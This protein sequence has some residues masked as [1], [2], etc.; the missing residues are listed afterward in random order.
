MPKFSGDR[1]AKILTLGAMCFALFMAMLDNTV[2]NVA[3][4]T[5]QR[6]L[7]AGV[8]GL[9][10]IVDGY[11]LAFA[12]LLLTGGILGDRYGRKRTFLI[13][14]TVFTLAS[15]G[16]GLS[17][18]AG[19]LIAARAV[20]GIGGALLM[21][22]T[23][24]IL[25][26]TVP[27][28]E[29]AKAIGTWAGISGL[30]LALG[31]TA[32]GWLI[33]HVGWEA[34]F[35]LNVPIGALAFAVAWRVVGESRAPEA[36]RLDVRGLLLGTSALFAGTYGLIEAN[37]LGWSD[38]R[39]MGSLG[40]AVMGLVAFVAWER[41][42]PH[43]MMPLGFFRV[44]AFAAGNAVAFA[45]SFGMFGTFFFFSLYMQLVRGY[46][47]LETGLRI[48]PVSGMI[49]FTAPIAGRLAQ[50]YGSRW[51]MT[52]GPLL[53]ASGMLGLSRTTT[54]T[55][56]T[57]MMPFLFAM[58]IGMGSTM[59]PMTATVM[60]AVGPARAGMGSA[61]TNTFREVGGVFGI[62]LLGTLLTTTLRTS[63][64]SALGGLGLSA[65][66]EAAVVAQAGHG[67]LDPSLLRG[68]PPAQARAVQEVFGEGFMRGYGLAFAVAASV[69]VA[70][71]VVA[72]RFVP[73]GP[74]RATDPGAPTDLESRPHAPAGG[75]GA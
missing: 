32:G 18:S 73:S 45:M 65:V 14:L 60:N 49:F 74:P 28:T 22:G 39:I 26:V 59:T 52:L 71:A 29:R 58:G 7:G 23:L 16:C 10:W 75:P 38:P 8:S 12:S 19:Q 41:H 6:E 3:L 42:H 33:E 25:T 72:N 64:T 9:Q 57:A 17:A 62:A 15:L 66:Q 40:A 13:G 55:P 47:A 46:S 30:A 61:T 27:P 54:D 43:A 31:P 1:R 36:R 24:S 35:F 53:A 5:L 48:V 56:F 51:L 63:L 68:F 69:L 70:A 4:P 34:I 21:P 44:P 2:V 37:Q 67:R 50:R 11:V 20:Q